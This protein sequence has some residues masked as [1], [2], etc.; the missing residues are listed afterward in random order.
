MWMESPCPDLI[1]VG[2]RF[3]RPFRLKNTCGV[4]SMELLYF[5]LGIS[6]LSFP[7]DIIPK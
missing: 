7:V 3:L 5:A 1:L 6:A 4:K 2:A